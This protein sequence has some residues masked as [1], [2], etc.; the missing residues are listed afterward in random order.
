M[1]VG[2]VRSLVFATDEY[3]FI[4][5]LGTEELTMFSYSDRYYYVFTC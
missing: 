3:I 1:F 5:L 4:I 2:Y